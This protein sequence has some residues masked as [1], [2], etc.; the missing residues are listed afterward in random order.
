MASLQHNTF[1]LILYYEA[2]WTGHLYW[3]HSLISIGINVIQLTTLQHST[4]VLQC[5]LN[6]TS[7]LALLPPGARPGGKT[8]H[9]P[10]PNTLQQISSTGLCHCIWWSVCVLAYCSVYQCICC[11]V[12]LLVQKDMEVARGRGKTSHLYCSAAGGTFSP[13]EEEPHHQHH[14]QHHHHHRPQN[15][16]YCQDCFAMN[17]SNILKTS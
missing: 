7:V 14:G 17:I 1:S 12:K 13:L 15:H 8:F 4:S 9:S 10:P 5:K 11:S 6:E 3:R 16:Y 2:S